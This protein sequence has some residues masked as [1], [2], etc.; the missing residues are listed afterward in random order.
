MPLKDERG[1]V[2]G[3]PPQHERRGR[4]EDPPTRPVN[5]ADLRLEQGRQRPVVRVGANQAIRSDHHHD[6]AP[7]KSPPTN[8]EECHNF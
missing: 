7:A 8:Q 2:G 1:R 3:K 5:P 6:E 4:S